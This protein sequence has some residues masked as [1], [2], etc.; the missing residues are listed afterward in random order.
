[1]D[2]GGGRS[3]IRGPKFD[4]VRI[5]TDFE[6][7][8]ELTPSKNREKIWFHPYSL[9]YATSHAFLW[10]CM[11]YLGQQVILSRWK[12]NPNAYRGKFCWWTLF[13]WIWVRMVKSSWIFG[14]STIFERSYLGSWVELDDKWAHWDYLLVEKTRFPVFWSPKTEVGTP[15]PVGEVGRVW[16]NPVCTIPSVVPYLVAVNRTV[17]TTWIR[18]QNGPRNDPKCGS[19]KCTEMIQKVAQNSARKSF[20]KWLKKVHENRSKSGSKK[21]TKIVQKVNRKYARIWS[22]GCHCWSAWN[23][24]WSPPKMSG[25]PHLIWSVV[26]TQNERWSPPEMSGGPTWNERWSPPIEFAKQSGFYVFKN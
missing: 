8:L 26:P 11:K 17:V 12:K 1:M 2:L 19:N 24:R 25:G 21:C 18:P 14:F 5:A 20:K 7:G 13:E 23:E 22:K 6:H 3:Q 15:Q 16:Q 10:A 9:F 4:H